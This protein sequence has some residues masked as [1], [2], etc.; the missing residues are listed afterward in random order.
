MV[1]GVRC[2]RGSHYSLDCKSQFRVKNYEGF[3][4][5]RLKII[6]TLFTKTEVKFEVGKLVQWIS[7]W[8]TNWV[9]SRHLYN[10][11]MRWDPHCGSTTNFVRDFSIRNDACSLECDWWDQDLQRPPWDAHG[12]KTTSFQISSM[13]IQRGRQCLIQLYNSNTF[14]PPLNW[15]DWGSEHFNFLFYCCYNFWM[16]IVKWVFNLWA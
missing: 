13:G 11:T 10:A 16:Q 14:F 12:L 8:T 4:T 15:T 2:T 1:R 9:L 6:Q 7:V 5:S 3:I